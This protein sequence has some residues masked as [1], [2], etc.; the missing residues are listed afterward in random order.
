MVL[1]ADKG[2]VVASAES[3]GDQQDSQS[4]TPTVKTQERY[5]GGVVAWL[6]VLGAFFLFFN[7]W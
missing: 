3:E 7:A 6:Q 2:G 4:S 5:D 1:P